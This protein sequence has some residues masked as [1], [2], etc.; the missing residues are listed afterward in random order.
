MRFAIYIETEHESGPRCGADAVAD[1]LCRYLGDLH[2][3]CRQ[4]TQ[5]EWSSYVIT[6][7]SPKRW[8]K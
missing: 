4:G 8:E 7:A 6:G 5:T 1:H 2:V 3:D